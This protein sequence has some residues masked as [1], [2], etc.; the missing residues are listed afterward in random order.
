VRTYWSPDAVKR[1]SGKELTG[2]AKDGIIHLINSGAAALEGAGAMKDDNGNT[3]IKPWYEMNTSDVESL[4][5]RTEWCPADRQYF[6]GGGFS[7]HYIGGTSGEFPVTMARLNLV[8]GFGPSLQIAEGYTC[9]L[10][11][12]IHTIIENRTDPTWPTTWFAP[13]LT[14]KDVFT[15]VYTVM[16]NWGAN[17]S[18]FCYGH[19]GADLIT[20]CSMLRIPVTMHNVD[21]DR[22][23]R[24]H[25]WSVIGTK[26]LESVD[27]EACKIY[28]P[29]YGSVGRF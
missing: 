9:E 29:L 6:R 3:I 21:S 1:V 28:G 16:A 15:N 10:D 25:A 26:D 17:H 4:M 24:P 20:L 8:R 7:S 14:G 11:Q 12:D 23:F 27:R 5:K 13:I 19:I 2:R 22:I 18:A